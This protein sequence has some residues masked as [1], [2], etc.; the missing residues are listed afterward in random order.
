LAIFRYRNGQFQSAATLLEKLRDLM[1][2]NVVVRRNLSAAYHQLDREDDAASELQRA[3]EIRPYAPIYTNLGT[4]RFYQ[5]R[6]FDALP[7]MERAVQLGAN[8]YIDWGN[9][10]DV[11][12]MLPGKQSKA[13]EAYATAIQLAREALKG[14]P[15]DPEVHSSLAVY[16]ARSGDKSG[17]QKELQALRQLKRI[18]TGSFFKAAI[19]SEICGARDEALEMLTDALRNGYPQREAAAEPDLIGLREDPRYH[20]LLTSMARTPKP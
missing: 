16:L 2:D 12:R 10:A 18:S 14:S 17:A 9:L 11:Y 15:D 1:P 4:I 19:V 6:Y 13:A 8:R 7:L 5:G 3:V 20:L